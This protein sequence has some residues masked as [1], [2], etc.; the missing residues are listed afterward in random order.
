MPH[1][2]GLATSSGPWVLWPQ[3]GHLAPLPLVGAPWLALA[4]RWPGSGGE[5]GE[6]L[7][8]GVW[9]R[10]GEPRPVGLPRPDWAVP[11]IGGYGEDV[12]K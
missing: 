10:G 8:E 4:R 7:E 1:H 12:G 5:E 2:H 6:G 3:A 11:G 9:S